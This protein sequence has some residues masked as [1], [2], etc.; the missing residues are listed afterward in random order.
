M[1]DHPTPMDKAPSVS[2]SGFSALGC[3]RI[4]AS[5]ADEHGIRRLSL[6]SRAINVL[7]FGPGHGLLLPM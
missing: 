5:S 7:R 6:F 1:W 4:S 2:R 3:S